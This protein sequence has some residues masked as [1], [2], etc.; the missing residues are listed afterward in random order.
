MAP[1][2]GPVPFGAMAPFWHLWHFSRKT[3]YFPA[4]PAFYVLARLWHDRTSGV[5]PLVPWHFFA[6][7]RPW[8]LFLRG[9]REL[10]VPCARLALDPLRPHAQRCRRCG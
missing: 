10:R 6:I 2:P 5:A 9:C 4:K 8:H 7:R 3:G 1:L